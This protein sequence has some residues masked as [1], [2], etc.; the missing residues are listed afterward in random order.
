[1]RYLLDTGIAGDVVF[2]RGVAGAR[3]RRAALEGHV[4]GIG[5]PVLAEMLYGVENRT[6]RRRTG[7]SAFSEVN[8]HG[9]YLSVFM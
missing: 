8:A 9:R 6:P 2:R 7:P 4:I 1:M 5:T 3:V